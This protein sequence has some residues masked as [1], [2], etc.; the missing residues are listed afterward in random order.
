MARGRPAQVGRNA[1]RADVSLPY[2]RPPQRAQ[3]AGRRGL[4]RWPP[5]CRWR[6][7]ARAW[8][9]SSRS[10][11][12]R[13]L[14]VQLAGRTRH[15]GRR[16]LQR[17]SR[18][19]ARG[20][21]RAGRTARPAPAGAGR[22]GRGGRPRAGLP[23]RGGRAMRASAASSSC[24]AGA[25]ASRRRPWRGGTSPTS[26]AL[27][28]RGAAGAAGRER[29]GQGLA[30]HEDGA[31]GAKPSRARQQQQ[32]QG[33]QPDAL[34]LAAWLQAWSPEFGFLRVFQYITF[35][36]V[37]AAMTALLIGIMARA[38]GDPP[39]DRTEDRPAGAR[40]RRCRRTWSRAARRPWAAC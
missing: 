18:F 3:R 16:Q 32:Q 8:S 2:R 31:G 22:H 30:L 14:G 13:A 23:R 34:S 15:A 7:R 9:A 37:M 10:R 35:R 29:A 36:A 25:W 39:P 24:V 11:A 26:P 33:R 40:L 6:D 12:A 20:D 4:A 5:A 28:R 17:Q 27:Q 21:R 38:L 19:G 1:R